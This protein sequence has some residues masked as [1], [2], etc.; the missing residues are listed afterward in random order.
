MGWSPT[1]AMK[2]PQQLAALEDR[3][4]EERLKDFYGID[5]YNNCNNKTHETFQQAQK[6]QQGGTDSEGL[7][8]GRRPGA[9]LFSLQH[10]SPRTWQR[11]LTPQTYASTVDEKLAFSLPLCLFFCQ[12]TIGVEKKII[13]I[14]WF[15]SSH[16]Y[17]PVLSQSSHYSKSRLRGRLA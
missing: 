4:W 9:L 5:W 2:I 13:E 11:K 8:K 10:E 17:Y 16:I 3:G 1:C 12:L 15:F 14:R 7:E 6:E